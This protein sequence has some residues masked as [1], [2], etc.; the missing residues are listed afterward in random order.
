MKPKTVYDTKG[1]NTYTLTLDPQIQQSADERKSPANQVQYVVVHTTLRTQKHH[2][3][4]SPEICQIILYM[5][6]F[7]KFFAGRCRRNQERME[8]GNYALKA[9]C[10]KI[11]NL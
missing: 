3:I 1:T 6:R 4:E 7:S 5:R 8:S 11:N 2:V 9:Y 10:R